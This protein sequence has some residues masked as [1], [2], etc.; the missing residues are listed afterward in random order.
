MM[1]SPKNAAWEDGFSHTVAL[2]ELIRTWDMIERRDV[3][4]VKTIVSEA[5]AARDAGNMPL[6]YAKKKE[7]S[8]ARLRCPF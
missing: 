8:A 3:T 1:S 2:G 7:L 5:I 4:K 6:Y